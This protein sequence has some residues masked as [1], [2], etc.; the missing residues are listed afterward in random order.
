MRW[1]GNKTLLR[2]Y[3]R[4]TDKAGWFSPI[5]VESL[6]H[7]AIAAH[8]P[9]ATV[10]RGLMG[11]DVA[12][13]LLESSSWSLVEHVPVLVE[14]I[15]NA[16]SIGRFLD[17]VVRI[18][19]EG[20]VTLSGVRVLAYRHDGSDA[21]A[22]W[23]DGCRDP[24]EPMASIPK[25][26]AFPI[27]NQAQDGR[28]LRVFI[29]ESDQWNGEPLYRA[30][31]RKAQEIGLAGA[32]VLRGAMSFGR[33]SA[34]HTTGIIGAT[35]DLPVV[36]EIIDA[37]NKIDGLLPFLEEAVVEGLVALESVRMLRLQRNRSAN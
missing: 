26:E 2:I 25:A 33:H 27:M 7:E 37:E 36:V 4:N 11:L 12:G 29:A 10:Y 8:L 6:L 24:H 16:D 9:G 21:P 32:T 23:T 13:K 3:L 22:S 35:D 19:V 1:D 15:D 20:T 30:I 28:L 34:V 14:F 17:A 18:V 5:A 31:V